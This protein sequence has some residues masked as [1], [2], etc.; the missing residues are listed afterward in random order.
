V[1]VTAR[2]LLLS[3]LAAC[4]DDDG[5]DG[6][7]P[8]RGCTSESHTQVSS[9]TTTEVAVDGCGH[10]SLG[11]FQVLGE[12]TFTVDLFSNGEQVYPHVRADSDGSVFRGL[13]MTGTFELTGEEPVRLWPQSDGDGARGIEDLPALLTDAPASSPWAGLVGRADGASAIVGVDSANGTRF[14]VEAAADGGIRAVWGGA[15][16]AFPLDE[17]GELFLDPL[18]V[19]VGP[20]PVAGWTLWAGTAAATVAVVPQAEPLSPGIV[21]RPSEGDGETE[22]AD[23]VAQA[24]AWRGAAGVV[25][26]EVITIDAGW[27]QAVGTWEPGVAFPSGLAAAADSIREA[28][29]VAGL[30]LAPFAVDPAA[31]LVVEHP[32]WWVTDSGGVPIVTDGLLAL[33]VTVPAAAAWLQEVVAA[34]HAEGWQVLVFGHLSLG[35]IEGGRSAPTTGT[36]A[37]RTGLGLVRAAAG[38]LW[39]V[40]ADAPLLPS[41]G[42]V[43]GFRGTAGSAV[44][45]SFVNGVWWWNDAGPLTGDPLSGQLTAAVIAGGSWHLPAPLSGPPDDTVSDVFGDDLLGT[46]AFTPVDALAAPGV[47]ATWT[48]NTITA[49]LNLTEEA[50]TVFG[51]GGFELL[52][53]GGSVAPGDRVLA[54]GAGE[55]WTPAVGSVR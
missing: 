50:V 2:F 7:P 27:E 53:D 16:E 33:D 5:D 43:D 22:L 25:P 31:P 4:S 49:L 47:P 23:A 29:L 12:G 44:G 15:G 11:D 10:V 13:L 55:V 42:L 19:W 8:P 45:R 32:D 34:R 21:V 46:A 17:N 52:T 24:V 20:D 35:A 38:S 3:S 9:A 54:A 40:A 14:H 28:G 48:S 26:P 1:T 36:A 30:W 39:L 41:A 18:F 51:P 37:Y 6:P